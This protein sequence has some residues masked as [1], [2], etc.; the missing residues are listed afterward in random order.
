MNTME[1]LPNIIDLY[2]LYSA[3]P[4]LAEIYFSIMILSNIKY[5]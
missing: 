3:I 5:I 2:Y 4:N 1:A